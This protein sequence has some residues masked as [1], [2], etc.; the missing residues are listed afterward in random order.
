MTINDMLVA[1]SQIWITCV[2]SY[3]DITPDEITEMLNHVEALQLII[4]RL[5][6]SE[7]ED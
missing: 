2:T 5:D 7:R 4:F 1:L 6:K 3:P